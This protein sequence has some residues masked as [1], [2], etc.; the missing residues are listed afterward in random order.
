MI[1]PM[2][3]EYAAEISNWAYENEYAIYSFAQS[4]G[5]VEELMNGEYYACLDRNGRLTGYFCFG[6]SAQ[7]PAVETGT[8]SPAMV[9]MGLGMKPILCGKGGGPAFVRFGLEF[10]QAE[11]QCKQIQLTVAA[12]NTRAIRT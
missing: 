1:V 8:Y 11:F 2:S 10:A 4:S 3:M 12:F 5:A 6:S 7:I 9:D